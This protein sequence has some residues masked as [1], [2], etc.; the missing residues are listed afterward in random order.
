M[1][2]PAFDSV[3]GKLV[4]FPLQLIP[5]GTFVRVRS[6]LNAGYRWRVGSSIHG[7]WLG[8][9]EA[10]GQEMLRELVRPGDV[11]YDL[12]ANAGFYTLAMARLTGPGGRIFAFEP[13]ASNA[14]NILQHQRVNALEHVTLV[15]A[16]VSTRGGLLPF[17]SRESNA[18]GSLAPSAGLASATYCVPTISLDE[19][20]F[21]H[22]FPAPNFMKIDVEGAETDV[23]RGARRLLRESH[24][25]VFLS[26]HSEGCFR[27]S[28][29]ELGEAG[30]L[31]TNR[32]GKTL[33]GDSTVENEILGR[34]DLSEARELR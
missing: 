12:G 6:G 10:E 25:R 28:I 30:Y 15:Q 33:S 21:G 3:L 19:F 5:G 26:I 22:G 18:M 13:L 8:T 23:L 27:E 20:V 31:V 11:C 1:K 34:A 16:A 7:C 9:Y 29:Q 2:A 32:A 4:R 24:P 17:V 14:A